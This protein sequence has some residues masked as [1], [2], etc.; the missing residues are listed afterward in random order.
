MKSTHK[1]FL[2]ALLLVGVQFVLSSCVADGYVGVDS[3]VYYGP[4]RDPWFYDDPWMDGHRWYGE[5]RGNVDIG[6]YLHP[7][8]GR[9]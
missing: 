4:R 2:G 1:F 8:R 7:P 5:P 9:R 3:G 6:I